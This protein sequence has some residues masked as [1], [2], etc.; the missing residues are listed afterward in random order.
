MI[1]PP[2]QKGEP[3]YEPQPGHD[4]QGERHEYVDRIPCGNGSI[5]LTTA[6]SRFGGSGIRLQLRPSMQSNYLITILSMMSFT[7]T[8]SS[9]R[10]SC[11]AEMMAEL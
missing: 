8:V 9:L 10:T 4:R 11:F 3:R 5:W 6:R 2:Q 7:V 1:D